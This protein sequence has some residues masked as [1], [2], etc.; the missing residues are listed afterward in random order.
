MVVRSLDG[1]TVEL[2]SARSEC[3]FAFCGFGPEWAPTGGWLVWI[4]DP[5]TIGAWRPG[6]D[7][8]RTVKLTDAIV[9][10]SY[11]SIQGLSVSTTE[12]LADYVSVSAA[13]G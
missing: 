1:T 11:L 2:G 4:V 12:R 9:D 13:R 7:G 8:P 6:L 3:F 10:G 5:S